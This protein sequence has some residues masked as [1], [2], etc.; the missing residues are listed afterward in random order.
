LIAR[1][2]S[3]PLGSGKGVDSGFRGQ[4]SMLDWLAF[5]PPGETCRL[6]GRQDANSVRHGGWLVEP[7]DIFGGARARGGLS[8]NRKGFVT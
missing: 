1:V 3:V 2:C 7:G 6:Y 4:G 8:P 5:G